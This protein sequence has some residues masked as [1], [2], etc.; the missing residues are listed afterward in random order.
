MQRRAC[1]ILYNKKIKPFLG[2]RGHKDF[3]IIKEYK[4][5]KRGLVSSHPED[6]NMPV[7]T[8]IRFTGG[9]S[10]EK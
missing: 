9:N 4:R 6:K 10:N 3:L 5:E 8:I 7:T 2:G 1:G